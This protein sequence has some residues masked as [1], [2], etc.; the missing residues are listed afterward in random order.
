NILRRVMAVAIDSDVSLHLHL[1]GVLHNATKAPVTSNVLARPHI[2]SKTEREC[3]LIRQ[4]ILSYL[5]IGDLNRA[6]RASPLL[7]QA[8]KAERKQLL[9]STLFNT[10]GTTILEAFAV[11]RVSSIDFIASRSKNNDA[12]FLRALEEH[13][14][15]QSLLFE[16]CTFLSEDDLV[17]MATFHRKVVWPHA[18]RIVSLE[19]GYCEAHDVFYEEIM[20][21]VRLSFYLDVLH[22]ALGLLQGQSS[23]L[24]PVIAGCGTLGGALSG[25][26]R[27]DER[28]SPIS[29]RHNTITLLQ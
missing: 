25:E 1:R 6:I 14:Q 24:M 5:D 12:L 2:E 8:F 20:A 26:I 27:M 9:L 15:K 29:L 23:D 19:A 13:R 21:F 28:A 10:L 22:A 7:F 3:V 4:R 11:H 17:Q 18:Q 16:L